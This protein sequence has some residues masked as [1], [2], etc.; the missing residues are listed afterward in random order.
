[1]TTDNKNG[2]MTANTFSVIVITLMKGVL[3][4]DRDARRWESLVNLQARIRDYVA[5]LG[6]EL[7]LDE[8]EGFAYLRQKP[9]AEGEEALPRLVARRQLGYPVSLLLVLLRKK[10]AEFDAMSG[11]SR[12]VLSRDVIVDM[13]RVFLQDTSNE[14]RLFDQIDSHINRIIDMGFL[15]RL[16]GNNDQFEVRRILKAFVDAQWLADFD[17]QLSSYHAQAN[18]QEEAA[19]RNEP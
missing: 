1:M 9:T 4:R 10:L 2:A 5:S 17:A 19:V 3:E 13:L 12:L 15:R 6:L 18:Q 8:S 16:R 11:E 7:I 14:A